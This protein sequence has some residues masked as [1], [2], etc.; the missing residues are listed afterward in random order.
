MKDVQ[1]VKYYITL[2]TYERICSTIHSSKRDAVRTY[3]IELKKFID[4]YK[5]NISDMILENIGNG[6]LL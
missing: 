3:F 4:Y 6:K 5:N 1:Q 2:D